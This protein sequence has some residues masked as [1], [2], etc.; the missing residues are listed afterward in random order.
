M[1]SARGRRV[2]N[3]WSAAVTLGF[4][5][6]VGGFAFNLGPTDGY[7]SIGVGATYT[8]DN[9]KIT[10]GVRYVDISDA[11]TT[12]GFGLAA[13]DFTDNDAVGLGVKVDW[14]C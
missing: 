7:K 11:Q 8:R 2:N 6:P 5:V 13:S 3:T 14:T 4:E 1:P 9:M 10:G 12:I